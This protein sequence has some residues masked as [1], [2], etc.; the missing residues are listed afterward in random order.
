MIDPL[1]SWIVELSTALHID[2]STIDRDVVIE[3]SRAAHSVARAAAPATVFLVGL[4]AGLAG[5]GAEAIAR[6]AAT[7]QQLATTRPLSEG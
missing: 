6:A 1:D 7:A 2:P 5:G 4:A 3:V